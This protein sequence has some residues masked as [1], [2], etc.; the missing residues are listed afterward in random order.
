MRRICRRNSFRL[1]AA[2]P[3]RLSMRPSRNFQSGALIS[4]V[5]GFWPNE[6]PVIRHPR[7]DEC[8]R[9]RNGVGRRT[10]RR[11]SCRRPKSFQSRTV[12]TTPAMKAQVAS[13]NAGSGVK[14]AVTSRRFLRGR[15]PTALLCRF[16]ASKI[17]G[18]GR[19]CARRKASLVALRDFDLRPSGNEKL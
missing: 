12:F 17:T 9:K 14:S 10:P 15:T 18:T 7:R 1:S 13:I 5:N 8:F 11:L 16:A 2:T 19:M 4:P 3:R 6:S